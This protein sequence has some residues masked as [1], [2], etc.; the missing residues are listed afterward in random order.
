MLVKELMKQHPEYCNL[1]TRVPDLLYIFKKYNFKEVVIVDSD[2]HPIGMVNKEA[3]SD[4]VLH[5]IPHPFDVKAKSLM[6]NIM[7]TVKKETSAKECFE[8]MQRNHLNV[9]PVTSEQG[10]CIGVVEKEDITD[11]MLQ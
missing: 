6:S 5:D 10:E 8:I 7:A 2:H 11:E 9:I 1:E 4:K 3:V